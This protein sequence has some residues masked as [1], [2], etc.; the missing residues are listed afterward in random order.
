MQVV[1]ARLPN[2]Y[3][4]VPNR[5]LVTLTCTWSWVKSLNQSR[6]HQCMRIIIIVVYAIVTVTNSANRLIK[7]TLMYFGHHGVNQ[8]RQASKGIYIRFDLIL[9]FL[10][11][12]QLGFVTWYTATA[13]KGR[14]HQ[15]PVNVS[16][17]ASFWPAFFFFFLRLRQ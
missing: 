5:F 3:L 14:V 11:L 13:K 15:R 9:P 1:E 12:F 17:S 16:V 4:I 7:H 6:T 2:S 10:T 8:L